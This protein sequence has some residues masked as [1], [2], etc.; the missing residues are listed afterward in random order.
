MRSLKRFL[1]VLLT[2][3]MMASVVVLPSFAVGKADDMTKAE[4]I[5][6]LGLLKGDSADG[7]TEEYLAKDST[8]MQM[9]ILYARWL[10]FEDEAYDFEGWSESA[11]FVDYDDSTS[12]DEYNMLAFYFD[13]PSLGF[14]G[15]GND[16]FEPQA[17]ATNKQLAKVLL[18]AMGYEYGVD[19]DWEDVLDFAYDLE[20]DLGTTEYDITN[21]D[22]ADALYDALSAFTVEDIT[23]AQYLM[24]LGI[25]TEEALI[26]AGVNY[27]GLPDDEISD[28]PATLEVTSVAA[29]NFAEVELT[30]N[31][32]VDEDTVK[33]DGVRV[34]GKK[35]GGNDKVYVVGDYGDGA[36]VRVYLVTTYQTGLLPLAYPFTLP[37]GLKRGR[38]SR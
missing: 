26:E 38:G 8:R 36:V 32:P 37:S 17:I 7:V 10:G 2:V 13:D 14:V 30:F 15:T 33:K 34:D 18:T 22:I 21:Q 31:Q 29:N 19:F 12:Q 28:L 1:A 5:A 16:M 27:L 9:A 3:A 6:H 25:V 23:F 20:I 24:E 11:N 35:L 4:A